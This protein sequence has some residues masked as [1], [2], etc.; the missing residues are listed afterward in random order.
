MD[1]Y[2]H[3]SLH[4]KLE[5]KGKKLTNEHRNHIAK[6]MLEN[7]SRNKIVVIDLPAQEA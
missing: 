3:R 5:R 7:E 4:M 1:K 6:G 2:Q